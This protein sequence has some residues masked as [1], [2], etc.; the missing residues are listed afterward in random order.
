[1]LMKRYVVY[2]NS[3]DC[4]PMFLIRNARVADFDATDFSSA[5][6]LEVEAP[7]LTIRPFSE[8]GDDE[9]AMQDFRAKLDSAYVNQALPTEIVDAVCGQSDDWKVIR[10]SIGADSA[11]FVVVNPKILR[12]LGLETERSIRMESVGEEMAQGRV[13]AFLRES[14][15][16]SLE[17][18]APK[19]DGS[20]EKYTVWRLRGSQ[21]SF[22]EY[23]ELGAYRQ[24]K[25]LL[26]SEREDGL[27][28]VEVTEFL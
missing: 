15:G 16:Y 8:Y 14:Y 12:S 1:M 26:N 17:V 2:W 23:N 22:T 25:I 5:T 9:A 13:W 10:C 18:L 6:E 27:M 4:D 20:F 21:L 28:E 3:G 7:G 24:S 11:F 19:S